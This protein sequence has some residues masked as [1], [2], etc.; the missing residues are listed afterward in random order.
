MKFL[1]NLFTN[2]TFLYVVVFLTILTVLGYMSEK[3]YDSV[4]FLI[5]MG[6]ILKTYNG[7]LAI[8]LLA[9][10]FITSIYTYIKTNTLEHMSGFRS[11]Y[12]SKS[13]TSN[14]KD[15]KVERMTNIKNTYND[16]IETI[17]EKT[18]IIKELSEEMKQK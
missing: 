10:V 6:L 1:E 17:K 18:A 13:S 3:R 9:A 2:K 12:K 14:N 11:R 15:T 16:L 7:N 5:A 8:I 4:V